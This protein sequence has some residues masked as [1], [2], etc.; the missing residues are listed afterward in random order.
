MVSGD[1][2]TSVIS[3]ISE[4]IEAG[5]RVFRRTAFKLMLFKGAMVNSELRLRRY[6]VTGISLDSAATRR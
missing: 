4:Q 6:T 1:K 5:R 2:I 3:G